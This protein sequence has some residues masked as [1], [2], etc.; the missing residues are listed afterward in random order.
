MTTLRMARPWRDPRTGMLMLR[1]R[2]PTRFRGVAGV[3]GDTVKIST[4]TKDDKEAARRWPDVLRQWAEREAEWERKLNVVVVTP[5]RA[6]EIAARWAAWIAGGAALDTGGETS[7]IFEPLDLPEERKPERLAR[8]WDRVEAHAKEALRVAGVETSH[9]TWPVLVTAMS[10]VVQAA[11][12]QADL[13][14]LDLSGNRAVRPLDAAREALPSVPDGPAP[15]NNR[16]VPTVSLRGL[17]D[18]WKTV[19]TVKPRVAAAT[20]Y[21]V[22][23][24]AEFGG[25]DDAAQIGREDMLRWREVTKQAGKNNNTWN[26]R[27]SMVRQV[28]IRAVAD[29][30]LKAD[31]TDRLRLPKE[32]STSW[33]PY[34]DADAAMIL[35]AARKETSPAL[36]WAHWI[37]ALTGMR[38]GEV[39]QLTGGDIR[40]D[41]SIPYIAI[42]E[43]DEGKSV[44]NSERRNVPI[45]P[46]L[47]A[48]SFL[49][50]ARAV[51]ADAPLFPDKRPDQ[52]GQ[53]GG[54]GWNLV[55]KWVREKVGVTD[56][57]LGP[58]HS[59]RHRLED[60]LRAMEVPEDVRDAIAGHA[61]KT[62]GRVY[63][64]RGEA[65]SRLHRALAKVP[66]PPEVEPHHGQLNPGTALSSARDRAAA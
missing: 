24:L 53:R 14:G 10:R 32:R 55:G 42:H 45:H 11:Y 18:A 38:V 21:I 48:E 37:M 26:N 47:V 25:H 4:G 61:R 57:R 51:A 41:G 49:D 20:G 5:E 36:R 23:Q 39:L 3:R 40:Q 46:A 50:Y 22:E 19:A 62:T 60:E 65:L 63:G 15:G 2:V 66:L 33:L 6:A 1:K 8:L 16:V 29:G 35:N 59:W 17:F 27:L 43:D 58:D 13:A 44:K 54:R 31:P 12:L 28:F 52:F 7:D 34:S 64:V 56:T 9:E 30:K